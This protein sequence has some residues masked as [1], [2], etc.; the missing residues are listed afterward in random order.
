MRFKQLAERANWKVGAGSGLCDEV[1][2]Q[3]ITT[4]D[5]DVP[6][7][8]STEDYFIYGV[9]VPTQLLVEDFVQDILAWNMTVPRGYGW[10][11]SVNAGDIEPF[12]SEPLSHSGSSI[13][14]QGIATLFARRFEPSGNYIEPNQKLTHV[15][16]LHSVDG[17]GWCRFN[18]LGEV[19]PTLLIDG[20]DGD[21]CT[22]D[23]DSLDFLLVAGELSLVRVVDVI[24]RDVRFTNGG[25]RLGEDYA[26]LE[27]EI[28]FRTFHIEGETF[29]ARGFDVV[30]ISPA[31]TARVRLVMQGKEPRKYESFT[32]LDWK[33]RKVTEWDADPAKIGNYFVPSELPFG[34]SPVFFKPDVLTQY[35]TDP[36]RFRVLPDQV[37]CIGAWSLRY[38]VNEDGQVHVYL[39]DLASIPYEEQLGW[40]R[41][42]EAPKGTIAQRAYTQDFKGEWETEYDPLL[43]LLQ[44]LQEF[45]A[46][47]LGCAAIWALGKLP[48]TRNLDVLGY[49][50]TESQKEFEDQ[51]L[52]LTQIVVEGLNR[53]GI[54]G[55]ADGLGCRDKQ[56]GSIKQLARVM[57][58]LG[59]PSVPR[60]AILS[61]LFELQECRSSSVAHRGSSKVIGD[62]RT[63]YRELLRRC[64]ESL[65]ALAELV[66]TSTFKLPVGK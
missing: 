19:V 25:S 64:D 47:P 15:L 37:E 60:G 21:V 59:V 50:V 27:H 5:G 42:N 56:L 55:L 38:Y 12:L 48:L 44:I 45:P 24:K 65:R 53:A 54:N 16:D 32:I 49:V 36:A 58:A 28:F 26:D 52:T 66:A 61:P 11:T 40:K 43:S 7:Y 51:I 29:S 8:V 14:D 17:K 34:T 13:L 63:Y 9:L 30:R 10:G 2:K 41:W 18:R 31:R 33:H 4:R 46:A 35:R 62:H 22:I 6:I 20:S 39:V 57:E 23:R 3:L 1:A